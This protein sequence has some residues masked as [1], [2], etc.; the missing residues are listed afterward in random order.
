VA[1]SL[2]QQKA[3]CDNIHNNQYDYSLWVTD[4]INKDVV[5]IIC[6]TH[7]KF[8]QKL[9]THKAGSGCPECGKITQTAKKRQ[10][11]T[12]FIDLCATKHNDKYDYSLIP[13]NV[14]RH[15]CVDIICPHHGIFNQRLN[16]HINGSGCNNCASISRGI[17][18]AK[19]KKQYQHICNTKHH[20]KYDYSLWSDNVRST[21]HVDIIC[22]HH[23]IFNQRLNSH[24]NG[25][26]CKKCS[27]ISYKQTMVDMFGVDHPHH[28]HILPQTLALLDDPQWL[29][30]Q[31]VT[32]KKPITQIA[33]E[34]F[35]DDTTVNRRLVKFNIPIIHYTQSM[36][37]KQVL[38]FIRQ[39]GIEALSGDRIMIKPYE[40]DIYIPSHNLAIE[41]CGLYWHSEQQGKDR[42]YHQNKHVLCK[43]QNIQLLTIFE[44][45]WVTRAPQVKR[46]LRH[47]LH[48]TLSDRIFARKCSLIDVSTNNKKLFFDQHH[49]QGNGPGSINLGLEHNGNLVACM[50]F[51]KHKHHHYYLNRYAT[52]CTVVGGFSKLL[53]WFENTVSWNTIVSFADNRWSNG[54]LYFQTGWTLDKVI[55]PDYSYSPD[56]KQRLHKFNYRRIHL[57]KKLKHYDELLSERQNCDANGVLRIWD[58]GKM[59]FI[60]RC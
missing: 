2:D 30:T 55:P 1:I 53:K 33:S 12:H 3:I 58:C 10:S 47:L 38:Q 25:S 13:K 32:Y 14:Q 49:I 51:I 41:Y 6:S 9:A 35:V 52:S 43:N 46:K 56:S 36:G 5:E 28:R 15:D 48:K 29:T 11:L 17:A 24:I 26:G 22:P 42:W 40:L 8:A 31:H 16:S 34:L 7:G 18:N 54:D 19:T 44:D 50:S 45:E 27:L 37:E 4:I 23:G 20:Q 21:N 57:P 59:R 39:L 60:K